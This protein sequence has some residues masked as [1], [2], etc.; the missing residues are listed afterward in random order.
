MLLLLQLIVKG[1]QL[2]AQKLLLY[3][4]FVLI[5]H[6]R[7]DDYNADRGYENDH[8]HGCGLLFNCIIFCGHASKIYFILNIH[9]LN[10]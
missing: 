3:L 7:S 1:L 6:V 10:Y 9:L 8:D 4:S 2:N 5:F